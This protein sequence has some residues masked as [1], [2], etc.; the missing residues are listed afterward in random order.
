MLKIAHLKIDPP[1]ILAPMAGITDLAFRLTC[2]KFGAPFTFVEMINCRSLSY[3]SRKT[4]EM[5]RGAPSDC[6]LGAQLLGSELQY[7]LKGLEIMQSFPVDLIDFNAACPVK[8]VTCRGEGAALMK[9]PKKLNKILKAMVEHSRL[10][11]TVKIRTGW[12]KDSVNA[13]E[14]AVACEDAGISALF[15]HGR[16][17]E[18][19]YSGEID[20]K[21][22]AKVKKAVRIPV[23]GS[24]NIWNVSQV[25]KMLEETGC[26]GIAVAR[27]AL[28]NPW[29]FREII[30]FFGKGGIFKRP[31]LEEVVQIFLEHLDRTIELYNERKAVLIFRKYLGWYFKG[32]RNVRLIRQKADQV[33]TKQD[34]I[35]VLI[36][37]Q[38]IDPTLE[39][40]ATG[41]SAKG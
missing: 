27:G 12:D 23:V 37:A 31:T 5:L 15:I 22:I 13:R 35:N 14:V 29:I 32:V 17:K 3:K 4:K 10:P 19:K 28:G 30:E 1:V 34:I 33:K 36:A 18:Q 7:I 8:K 21:T 40:V 16:H 24:G 25:K 41:L 9:T 11:V 20:Y 2:R 39:V 26:D 38:I 6:P